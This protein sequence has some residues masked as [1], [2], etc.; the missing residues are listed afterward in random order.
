[1]G[2]SGFEL[3]DE[4]VEQAL[5]TGENQ[6]LL[7]DLFGVEEYAE[8]RDLAREVGS[9][10]LRGGP[11]VLIL[12][13]I[14][15]SK[16]GI[17]T[18][19]SGLFHDVYWFDPFDVAAGR[20]S[21][22]ALDSMPSR[23]TAL[24]V[25]LVAYLKLKLRLHVAGYD[26]QFH[27][28]DWRRSV[29][30]L[31]RELAARLAGDRGQVDIVAHSMGG[32]VARAALAQ[33]ARCRRLIMLGTPNHG[34]FAPVEALRGTYPVVRKIAA[35]DLHHTAEDLAAEVF[36]TFP[37]LTD[38]LPTPAVFGS[39]DLYDLAKW[40]TSGSGRTDLRPRAG[41]LPRSLKVQ[42]GLAPGARGFSLIA[43]Y[44]SRTV[45]G[46]RLAAGGEEFEYEVSLEGDGT[47][48]V[49]FAQLSGIDATYYVEEGHGSLPN[50]PRVARAVIDLLREG[51]TQELADRPEAQ[52]RG[53][54]QLVKE[55]ALRIEPYPGRRGALLSQ[56]ELRHVLDE[57]A[58]PVAHDGG[59]GA[60]SA[61]PG[62]ALAPIDGGYG[63]FFQRVTVGRERQHRVDLRF[64]FGSITDVSA[65]AIALG[66]F[67]GVVPSGAASALDRRL[68]GAVTEIARRQMFSGNVGEVFMLPTKPYLLY[69]DLAVFVGLGAFDRFTKDVIETAAEN[70]TRTLLSARV[71][72]F[73]TVMF[74]GNSGGMDSAA[75]LR[76]MLVGFLRGLVDA[77]RDHRF[78]RIVVCEH[79]RD[80]YLR[81]KEE[82]Y[83]L[84]STAL[85]DDIQ[86]TFDEV[87]LPPEPTPAPAGAALARG[88]APVYLLARQERTLGE[89]VFEV[90]SSLLTAGDKATVVTGP[91][92]VDSAAFERLRKRITEADAPAIAGLGNEL[93]AMLLADEV[94]A[95]LPQF[96]E[97]PLIV[98]HDRELSLVPWEV[99]AFAEPGAGP[100]FP[101]LRS[102]LSHRFAADNLSV[103]K[104]LE[105][106]VR[107]EVLNVLLVV[108][109]TGDLDGAEAEAERIRELLGA[110][111]RVELTEIRGESATR[112]VLLEAFRSGRYDVLHYAGHAFF[113]PRNPAESG[114]LCAGKDI[115]SGADLARVSNL[116]SLVFFN[117]CEAARM[118]GSTASRRGRRGRGGDVSG[119]AARS[120]KTRLEHV[121]DGAGLAEAFMRGGVASFLGTYWPVSDTAA[122]TFAAEFYRTVMAGEPLGLALHAGREAIRD[123]RDWANYVFYGNPEFVVKAPP[124]TAEALRP[125]D[126]PAL[127]GATA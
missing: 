85:C 73:A 95:V 77:D 17:S 52:V 12:P 26:A 22:L 15:G 18:G 60:V 121:Q 124:A 37:G 25:M 72:E 66:I 8:L 94:R 54:A 84:S 82:M 4:A 41:L 109:P 55:S 116:P 119:G 1:V 16:I 19:A 70:V 91:R 68:D 125:V 107:D 93:A 48:P 11:K 98:V 7:A 80:R 118:R 86:L 28:F 102:G 9:R 30:D 59:R 67:K 78:R 90:R 27:P 57:V 126:E 47:V 23:F 81:L 40:P 5:R 127:A 35:L 6:E 69:A 97:N 20:L 51:R 123:Q 88:A 63:H 14:M 46:L 87:I 103:A 114:I 34:S 50:N 58:S 115:L 117:A 42:K 101:A 56:R 108:N 43:G 83:R 53:P 104:W 96:K 44:G 112:S 31:G 74:G 13:G 21:E 36:S 76:H 65:P 110:A 92:T 89:G 122:S 111:K 99:L 49:E 71:D 79:E 113:D 45:T 24:G 29:E 3:A 100:W 10:G 105:Q 120:Q 38:M 39:Y 32:L 106:R 61:L 2:S 64:A 75:G 62:A 33:G